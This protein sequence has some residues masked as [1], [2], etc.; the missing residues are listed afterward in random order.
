MYVGGNSHGVTEYGRGKGLQLNID[1]TDNPNSTSW[2]SPYDSNYADSA[3]SLW[4]SQLT[5]GSHTIKG[6]FFANY[7]GYNVT[8]SNRQ[9]L[10]LAFPIQQTNYKL[11]IEVQWTN[12][13]Y[14][15]QNAQL[16]IYTGST[17]SNAL[18]V[19]YWNGSN[20]INLF[21]NLTAYAWNNISAA[22][23]GSNFTIRFEAGINTDDTIQSTWNI[24]AV[25][26]HLWTT[27]DQYT[28]EVE[29]TGFRPSKLD[30][31]RLASRQQL[32]YK[33]SQRDNPAL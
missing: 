19:D 13:D 15:Q 30:T 22:L 24:D 17:G 10:I 5:A 2:Q 27:N 9:L 1:A 6:R 12:V 18:G 20:W 21:N 7:A 26:L 32:E 25:L 16:C 14:S 23:T 4:Y 8:V 33:L 31:T 28:A 29:F 3:T 11:D